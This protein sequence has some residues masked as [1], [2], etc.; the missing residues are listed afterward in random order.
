MVRT[1]LYF[2]VVVEHE[3]SEKPERLGQEISRQIEK[4]YAVRTV[5]LTG[6]TQ[7]EE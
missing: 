6:A 1:N 3:K 4:L 5:E 2:K 7:V